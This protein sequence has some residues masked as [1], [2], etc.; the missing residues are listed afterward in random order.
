[1]KRLAL[2]SAM[3]A[4]ALSGCHRGFLEPDYSPPS[5]PTG[6]RTATGDNFIEVFW[7][8]NPE[9]DVQ[10]YNIYAS[11]SYNGRYELIG[12]SDR[13][14][15]NDTGARNGN[16]Y[17]YAVTAFDF[18]GN[19]SALSR[20]VAY[21]IPRPEGYNVVLSD[22]RTAPSTAGYD[23]SGYSVVAYDDNTSD[24]WYEY[25]NGDYYMDVRTDTDIRD[26]GPTSSILDISTAPSSGWSTTHDV[27]LTVGHTYVVWTFDDHYA[28]FR[29][30]GMSASRVTFD[31][32]YQLQKSNPL[33]KR[34]AVGGTASRPGPVSRRGN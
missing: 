1:M 17:Y 4:L 21:D 31:W 24:M 34:A 14:Y 27:L 33:L 16:T 13:A 20:D 11:S 28:K 9:P 26:M 10:G 29:V 18:D 7:N 19:E 22:F 12:S 15:F 8:E 2:L 3:F 30:S 25:Y 6:L 32:A 23:F 5:P